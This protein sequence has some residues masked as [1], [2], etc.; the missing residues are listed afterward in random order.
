MSKRSRTIAACAAAAATLVVAFPASGQTWIQ[1]NNWRRRDR[2][3]LNTP[4]STIW[5]FTFELR[6][7]AYYPRID[8]SFAPDPAFPCG[9]P[10]QCFFGKGAQ[11]YF[12]LEIDWFPFRIPYVGRIGP[13][14]GWGFVTYGGKAHNPQ[15]AD[16]SPN[17]RESSKAVSDETTGMTLI[18]M[19]VSAVLRIDEISRRTVLPIVP[20]AKAGFGFG[21][22]NSGTSKGTSKVKNAGKDESA[23]GLSFGPHIALGGMLGLNWLDR[24]SSAMAR[25]SSGIQQAY[26]F[27]EWMLADL[28]YSAKPA[29][30]NIGTSTWVVGLAVDF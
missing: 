4:P 1:Q 5:S 22:W 17:W 29:S 27:G 25:E 2:Y 7:G 11:F 8:D 23:E 28:R 6:M 26:L 20:Y 14:L 21:T 30:M 12:G 13:A 3:E 9:G 10:Y 18:P 16:W 19:H 24:R 15:S